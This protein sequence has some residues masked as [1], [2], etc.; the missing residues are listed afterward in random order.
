MDSLIGLVAVVLVL[1]FACG[2]A[3]GIAIGALVWRIKTLFTYTRKL[4]EA[5]KKMRNRGS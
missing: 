4:E 5:E 1:A 3:A 2:L